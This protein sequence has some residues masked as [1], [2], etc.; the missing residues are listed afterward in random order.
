[1]Q[2]IKGLFVGITSLDYVFYSMNNPAPDSKIITNEYERYVGGPATNAAI[3]YSLL[4]GNATLI[5]CLGSDTEG[6]YLQDTIERFGVN[7]INCA[8]EKELPNISHIVVNE[9]GDRAV[10]SGQRQFGNISVPDDKIQSDFALFDMNQQDMSLS[11][12]RNTDCEIVLDAGS[13]KGE[14]EEYLK[15]ADIVI[16]SEH[17]K[18]PDGENVFKIMECSN[19]K[20]AITR[21][22]KDILLDNGE[23]VHVDKTIKCIDSLAAGDIF[24]GAFCFAYYNDNKDFKDAIAFASMIAGESVKYKGPR[25]WSRHIS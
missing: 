21:G 24:H 9:N 16:S 19:A 18:S 3:T 1:M 20:K 23:S 2:D 12:L 5:T 22:G 17:F 4:G 13:W 8:K 7:V 11:I 14:A 6:R 10:N 25:E 15:K